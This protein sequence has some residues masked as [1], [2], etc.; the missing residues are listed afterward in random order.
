MLNGAANIAARSC[1][2][3]PYKSLLRPILFHLDAERA[4]EIGKTALR[5][6]RFWSI[7]A[8]R[9][10]VRDARLEV[11]LAGV[12]LRNPV[13][14]AAGFDK[15]CEMLAT[16]AALGFGY[17]IPGSIRGQ[18]S[19]DNP[20]PRILRYVDRESLI[21]CTGFPSRGAAYSARRLASFRESPLSGTIRVIPNITGF[22][23]DEYV[24]VLTAVQPFAD[25]IEISLSCPNER[26]DE[27][28]FLYPTTFE[29]LMDAL[30]RLKK[31]PFLLKIRNYND[32][33]ERENRLH[34]VELALEHGIDAVM[35]PGSHIVQE[36]RLSLGR[37]NLGGRA[38]FERTLRNI[39][40][41]RSISG[42]S[43]PIKALG[44]IFTA[45]DAFRAIA[46]GATTVELLT[47]LVYEGVAVARRINAGLLRLLDERGIASVEALIGSG[48][49]DAVQTART[50]L[51][52]SAPQSA[53]RR[54]A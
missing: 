32:E 43:V 35:L 26:Y 54:S 37:G 29:R 28:D 33:R 4:H 18:E 44:G 16:M 20:K 17:A 42:P 9:A 52:T 19:G 5:R 30:N 27:D 8:G 7:A 45:D 36:P 15:N 48:A 51:T 53:D 23:V 2:V 47:G 24:K 25:A 6:G 13:G 41:V 14:L 50:D 10:P 40:D 34:L 1:I 22:T 49:G 21:N 39:H 12:R 46:A 11:D 3:D 38:V 31:R